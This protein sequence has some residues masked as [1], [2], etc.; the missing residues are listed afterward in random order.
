MNNQANVKNFIAVPVYSGLLCDQNQNV[1]RTYTATVNGG[2]MGQSDYDEASEQE[3]SARVSRLTRIRLQKLGFLVGAFLI[4]AIGSLPYWINTSHRERQANDMQQS[5]SVSD[6][7]QA[8]DT[9][10]EPATPK[11]VTPGSN[12]SGHASTKLTVNGEAVPL[13]SNGSLHRTTSDDNSKTDLDVTVHNQ[14]TSTGNSSSTSVNL[15]T[16]SLSSGN[17]NSLSIGRSPSE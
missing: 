6:I 13:P 7:K 14:S 9:Q 17:Q 15:Q 1:E 5:T 8:A 11:A 10:T 12:T 3:P 2:S 4:G 16:S